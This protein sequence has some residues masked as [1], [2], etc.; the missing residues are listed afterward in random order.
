MS[1]NIS[2]I[3][4]LALDPRRDDF[5][6]K[7]KVL[8]LSKNSL[9]KEAIKNLGEVLPHN[10]II[11]VLDLSKNAL[12]VSG[13][14]EIAVAF[15][16]NKS[17][18]SLNLFNNR[19]GFDGAKAVAEN[20]VANHPTLELLELGHNRIRNKGLKAIV[21]ALVTNKNSSLKVLGTRFNFLTN[22]GI[23]YLYNKIQGAKTKVEEI[24]V[25]NNL[26]DDRGLYNLSQIF[27]EDKSKLNIDILAKVK[28]LEQEKS[29][30]TIWVHPIMGVN[31][32]NLKKFL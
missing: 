30:R 17:L 19:I 1:K 29:E 4:V 31:L 7:I 14:N 25:K 22:V 9:G 11:E 16:N 8:N 24:F 23:T 5:V 18:K 32:Q 28:Y 10:G 3:L 15:K 26:M 13:A 2:D 12:G 6:S 27:N 20:I 21:D